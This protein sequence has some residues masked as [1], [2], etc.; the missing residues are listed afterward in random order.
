MSHNEIS[1]VNSIAPYWHDEETNHAKSPI[2]PKLATE[3][4][5]IKIFAVEKLLR[6]ISAH[7]YM[8]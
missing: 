5:S 4:S 7:T 8:Y 6:R 1:V 2:G 3:K